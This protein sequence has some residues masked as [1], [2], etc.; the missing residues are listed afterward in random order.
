MLNEQH[1][2]KNLKES[3]NAPDVEQLTKEIAQVKDE[4]AV[5]MKLNK[6]QL[7]KVITEIN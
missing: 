7:S 6:L 2:L 3:R 5:R 4:I 1:K